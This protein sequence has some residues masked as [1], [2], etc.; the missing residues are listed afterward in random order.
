[1]VYNDVIGVRLFFS[2]GL[3]AALSSLSVSSATHS[4]SAQ[5]PP[6]LKVAALREGDLLF[7]GGRGWRSEVVRSVS[8]S[9]LTHVGIVDLGADGQVYVIHAEPPEGSRSG[10]VRRQSLREFANPGRATI[11]VAYRPALQKAFLRQAVANAQRFSQLGVPFDDDFDLATDD[12]L[13]CSELIWKAFVLADLPFKPPQTRITF[14]GMT[15]YYLLPEDIMKM[16][17]G[18]QV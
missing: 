4:S 11:L 18:R 16:I 17:P 1:M 12:A 6:L 14:P 8:S 7:R 15:G 3:V 13:Y 9:T 5:D 2:G 10:K